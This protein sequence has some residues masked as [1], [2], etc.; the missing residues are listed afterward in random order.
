MKR[1]AACIE[2]CG[3]NYCGWQ[4]QIHSPSI[5]QNVEQ[6]LTSV[7]NEPI[8]ITT[9]GRTDTGVHGIGQ[10][11]H[12]D[13]NSERSAN[14]WVRGA[15][16]NLPDDISLV[17]VHSVDS[18]FHARF[19]ALKR[20]YRYVIFNRRVSPSY[21]HGRITWHHPPL[22]LFL[23]QRAAKDLVGKH[24]FSA[25]RAAGCQ[26]KY[27]VKNIYNLSLEQSSHW[28]WIDIVADGF[29]QHMVRNIAGVLMR[30]GEKLE[31]HHWAQ[32]VLESRDRKTG[33]ITAPP[34]GLYFVS[35][36]YDQKYELPD[37]PEICRFW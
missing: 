25:F 18:E 33:G 9:A 1:I 2:Y 32:H 4:R 6:A 26:S 31:S 30:I 23:M 29:L 13:T 20:H 19:S 28:I 10:M 17:W 37:P 15:N 5:Q 34:D 24:D 36:E 11:I 21:L 22:N 35:V 12:F 27:P 7:A 16:T 14:E 3:A 8:S